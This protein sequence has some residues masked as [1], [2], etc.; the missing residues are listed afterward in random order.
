MKKNIKPLLYLMLILLLLSMTF[1]GCRREAEKPNPPINDNEDLNDM[2]NDENLTDMDNIN[3][4][5]N[6]VDDDTLGKSDDIADEL[7]KM[8]NIEDAYVLVTGNTATVAVDLGDDNNEMLDDSVKDEIRNKIKDMYPEIENIN[9]T[10]DP[11]V[12]ERLG[13]IGE[14][15]RRGDPIDDFLDEIRDIGDRINTRLQ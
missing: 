6:D 7:A 9:V 14:S 15:I 1:V 10:S 4:Y 11:D 8:N 3:D 12:F 2:N 13:E 5:D